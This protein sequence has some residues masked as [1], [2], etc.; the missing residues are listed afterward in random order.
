MLSGWRCSTRQT[1]PKQNGRLPCP[2]S[3]TGSLLHLLP[4][5]QQQIPHPRRGMESW[6]RKNGTKSRQSPNPHPTWPPGVEMVPEWPALR[7]SS[8][9]ASLVQEGK[10]MMLLLLPLS[11]PFRAL[12]REGERNSR[13]ILIRNLPA[14]SSVLLFHLLRLPIPVSAVSSPST[15]TGPFTRFAYH[16]TGLSTTTTAVLYTSRT[17]AIETHPASSST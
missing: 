10:M 14:S 1:R 5:V 12:S 13:Y 2:A 16:V 3:T 4:C 15:Y 8:A 9:F 7:K 11:C 17:Q 6:K